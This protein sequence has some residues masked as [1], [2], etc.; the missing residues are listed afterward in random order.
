EVPDRDPALPAGRA[1]PEPAQGRRLPDADPGEAEGPPDLRHPGAAVPRILRGSGPEARPDRRDHAPAARAPPGQ[2]CLPRG[3][4]QEPRHGPSAGYP[5][6]LHGERQ[7]GRHRVLP[8]QRERHHRGDPQVPRDDAVRHRAGRGRRA[9]RAGLARG[10]VGQDADSGALAA[11]PG[12][13]RH[14]GPGTAH[15]RVL[16]EVITTAVPP[17]WRHGRRALRP[18]LAIVIYR[19]SGEGRT[20]LIAQRPSLAEEQVD[21]YRSRFVIEPLEPGFGYT[22]G[23]SLR[24]PPLSSIPG[25]AVTSIRIEGVLHEFS[26]VPGVKEDVTDIIL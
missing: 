4:R 24:R 17:G 19:A 15:R 5:R 18:P 10:G 2:R 21:E 26:T 23:N 14:P 6:P 8:G 12:A 25:A 7:E 1:R 20:M 13:D 11:R 9:H 16:L 3:L 22:I